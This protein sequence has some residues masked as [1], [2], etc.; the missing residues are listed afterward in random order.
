[1]NN[2]KNNWI[3]VEKLQYEK[4]ANASRMSTN[5]PIFVCG[6]TVDNKREH[7]RDRQALMMNEEGMKTRLRNESSESIPSSNYNCLIMRVF[8]WVAVA[9]PQPFF[10]HFS[11]HRD[12][13]TH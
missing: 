13:D 5:T 2:S 1:M 8:L 3:R 12:V 7:L 4:F 6:V 11:I 9:I 10:A